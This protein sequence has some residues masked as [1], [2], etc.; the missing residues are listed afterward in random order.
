MDD[1]NEVDLALSKLNN[2]LSV[3]E[4][5]E[6]KQQLQIYINHLLLHDFN[7]LVTILYRVDVN[8][9]KLKRLLREDP[10]KDSAL[11]IT[12]LLIERQEEKLKSKSLSKKDDDISED[13]KW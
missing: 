5:Q 4:K 10:Q 6:L 9:Q 13:E 1:N 8:E 12:D 3:L 11:L 2:H 7:K